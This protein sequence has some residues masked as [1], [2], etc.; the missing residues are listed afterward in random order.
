MKFIKW[1]IRKNERLDF[2]LIMSYIASWEMKDG[3]K[4]IINLLRQAK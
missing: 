2:R 1:Q 3:E 4:Y